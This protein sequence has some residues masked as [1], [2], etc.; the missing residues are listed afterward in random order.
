MASKNPGAYRALLGLSGLFAAAAILTLVPHKGASWENVLGYKSLCTF[1]PVATAI[2][3]FLA[4]I[5]C[6]VRARLVG[7]RAG[8]KRGW[9]APVVV[10]LVLLAVIALSAPA[11]V[12]AKAE[13]V[14]GATTVA[15]T[16]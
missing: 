16:D 7:P 8:D 1:A 6:V 10:G 12:K 3:A 15:P 4:G 11:Y 14:S 13:A 5:T 2:C 9:A